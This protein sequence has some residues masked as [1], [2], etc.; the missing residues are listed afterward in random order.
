MTELRVEV[1]FRG[2]IVFVQDRSSGRVTHALLREGRAGHHVLGHSYPAQ[3]DCSVVTQAD[4]DHSPR[5]C[6]RQGSKSGD[7]DLI[8]KRLALVWTEDQDSWTRGAD[9][10][11]GSVGNFPDFGGPAARSFSW[12]PRIDELGP[13][14]PVSGACL[15]M[16]EVHRGVVG[17][18]VFPGGT[19]GTGEFAAVKG[20]PAD[21]DPQAGDSWIPRL[22]FTTA[23]GEPHRVFRAAAEEVI[24]RPPAE[25]SWL[26]LRTAEFRE[27]GSAAPGP[28]SWKTLVRFD[29]SQPV[30]VS[31][32][33]QSA[34]V[35]RG[36]PH[37]ARVPGSPGMHFEMFYDLLQA[38]VVPALRRIPWIPSVLRSRSRLM[39]PQTVAKAPAPPSGANPCSSIDFW[40]T[41]DR[42]LCVPATASSG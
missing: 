36:M 37:P 16:E 35:C 11:Q 23:I 39:R 31:V 14:N 15:G 3:G 21:A 33:N 17:Q 28:P 9:P 2:L 6:W 13:N 30:Q 25:A 24:W 7:V 18:V 34:R 8:R 38:P 5:V 32:S 40:G 27:A 19:I 26:E 12:V 41:I 42:P 1:R 29:T 20:R 4:F 10:D 22:R